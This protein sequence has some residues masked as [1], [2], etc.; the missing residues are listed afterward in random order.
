MSKN[1]DAFISYRHA[2]L[3]SYVAE[4]VQ[5]EL[6]RYKLPKRVLRKKAS[7][8]K[9]KIERV[10]LDQE[11][12]GL[13]ADLSEAIYEALDG[14][15]YLIVICTPRLPESKWCKREIEYFIR[16]HGE[17][18]VLAVLAEGE[19]Q[20]AFPEELTRKTICCM[21]DGVET[22]KTVDIEPLA[23]DVRGRN[24]REIRRKIRKAIVRIAAVLFGCSY[25]ELRQRHREDRLRRHVVIALAFMALFALFGAC[26]F[27]QSAIILSQSTKLSEQ[28]LENLTKQ[29]ELI[30]GQT[31]QYLEE[32]KVQ[33]AI[34]LNV[35]MYQQYGNDLNAE[36]KEELY[37]S[38]AEALGVYQNGASVIPY[39]SFLTSDAIV[40]YRISD[41][42][43]HIVICDVDN[44][45]S[46]WSLETF[47][48]EYEIDNP[49][50]ECTWKWTIMMVGDNL[51]YVSSD[52]I[53][54]VNVQTRNEIGTVATGNNSHICYIDEDSFLVCQENQIQRYSTE[55]FEILASR[56][57]DSINSLTCLCACDQ[58][59]MF[60]IYNDCQ[61]T[62]VL[63]LDKEDLN[64]V[65]DVTLENVVVSRCLYMNDAL[66]VIANQNIGTEA[67]TIFQK[68][69]FGDD[70]GTNLPMEWDYAEQVFP[71]GDQIAFM[72]SV[73]VFFFDTLT[74]Q[75][76]AHYQLSR[77]GRNMYLE[78]N[79]V[80]LF[81]QNGDYE[82]ADQE[83]YIFV[84]S[85]SIQ[86]PTADYR[87]IDRVGNLV[88]TTR[89]SSNYITVYKIGPYSEDKTEMTI[90][91]F[92]S[93]LKGEEFDSEE[94]TSADGKYR[95]VNEEGQINIYKGKELYR[96]LPC[97]N[98]EVEPFLLS[99]DGSYL[100]VE[101]DQTETIEIYDVASMTM[102]QKTSH[103]NGECRYQNLGDYY[104]ISD[105]TSGYLYVKESNI[106]MAEIHGYMGYDADANS[107]YFFTVG[108]Y[109]DIYRIPF[110]SLEELVALGQKR[111]Y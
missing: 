25:E 7:D 21:E 32:G 41:N 64:L 109:T 78:G 71:L 68:I 34:A 22:E 77:N 76:V 87:G 35:D 18:H 6:E 55:S 110:Y 89:Y 24:K 63:S 27:M 75:V 36:G 16:K 29:A 103:F 1:Y 59:K 61:D 70:Q 3:D 56:S 19:P 42:E 60:F 86:L 65:G 48:K 26:T 20:E 54:V 44:Y 97:P 104:V 46:V 98:H 73:E 37:Y 106:L 13:A 82:V 33:D 10:F 30:Q 83:D 49:M 111:M 58:D 99:E 57:I 5:R 50:E 74:D 31:E 47:E 2:E 39:A 85:A 11:D 72:T 101:N 108:E 15:E 53:H 62:Q 45:V 93:D 28:Y 43:K 100:L 90:N 69:K 9:R 8:D 81:Y 14:S 17:D 4:L 96:S 66:Y 88:I 23:A 12:L 92:D 105:S 52:Q 91:D 102:V 80:Y 51:Y 84:D 67:Q 79:R 95:A 38:L 94:Y 40:D 107:F